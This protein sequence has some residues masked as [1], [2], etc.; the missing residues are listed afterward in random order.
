MDFSTQSMDLSVDRLPER[1]Y[2]ISTRRH[3]EF[4]VNKLLG[5]SGFQVYLPVREDRRKW[6]HRTKLLTVPLFANYL[7]V[8]F[9]LCRRIDVLRTR[10]VVQILGNGHSPIPVPD[11]Q[12]EAVQIMEQ[13]GLKR[14]PYPFL[15]KG[16]P[17]RVKR[18]LLDGYEGM[19]LRKGKTCRFV[20]CLAI[21]GQSV[22]VEIDADDL[23][24][25]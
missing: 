11:D 23:E 20:V 3:H 22:G 1:W 2:A 9:G 8:R 10:G 13:H 6:T 17:V 15:V 14:D 16:K 18:G 19:L 4:V 5:V 21:L 7:F 24:T 12:I 25:V